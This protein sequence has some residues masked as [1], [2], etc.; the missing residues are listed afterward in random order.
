MLETRPLMEYRP[1][2]EDLCDENE[3]FDVA[4]RENTKGLLTSYFS[5]RHTEEFLRN[6]SVQVPLFASIVDDASES[7]YYSYDF[8]RIVVQLV[9]VSYITAGL[10]YLFVGKVDGSKVCNHWHLIKKHLDLQHYSA[11]GVSALRKSVGIVL[12]FVDGGYFLNLTCVPANP[13][14]AHPLFKSEMVVKAHA[15]GLINALFSNFSLRL[16]SL[17]PQDLERPTIQKNNL[18]NLGRMNILHG[19]QKFI[20]R[21]FH[22]SLLA[23]N[24]D[25]DMAIILNISKFGQKDDRSFDL[26]KLVHQNGIVNG[27][28]HVACKIH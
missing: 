1:I 4:S 17:S 15:I 24:E 16:R 21:L 25:I 19:D 20:L 7:L 9:D 22:Q 2:L 23:V 10:H 26:S 27:S 28:Y 5:F 3:P 11:D 6:D 8:D 13:N 18:T 14:S 12:A